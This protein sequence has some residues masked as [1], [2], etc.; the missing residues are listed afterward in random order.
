[1]I[2]L[3]AGENAT[4]AQVRECLDLIV[5]EN[6][7]V[8][9]GDP[10]EIQAPLLDVLLKH[11]N[12]G[13]VKYLVDLLMPTFEKCRETQNG[14]GQ[15]QSA[16]NLCILLKVIELNGLDDEHYAAMNAKI[17][18]SIPSDMNVTLPVIGA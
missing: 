2:V 8:E 12:P 1:M 4:D 18:E 6:D 16:A 7:I 5:D 3:E 11:E 9:M 15:L 17:C 10:M 13:H 14:N